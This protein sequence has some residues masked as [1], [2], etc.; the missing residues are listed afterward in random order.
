MKTIKGLLFALVVLPA[1]VLAADPAA[2][3]QEF[4]DKAAISGMFEVKASEIAVRRATGPQVKSFA[5]MMVTDHSAANAKLKALAAQKKV[6]L[7]STLDK[8]H[9]K[10]LDKLSK[11]KPGKDFDETYVDL[12]EDGH[13]K[14]VK[15]FE[16]ASKNAKDPDVSAFAAATLPTLR[17]HK[18][19][20]EALDDEDVA[21]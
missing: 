2:P 6:V 7:P 18:E 13:D 11:A 17:Q 5:E 4:Y 16:K 14:A 15:L 8:D 21:P 19:V 1:C 10:S 3:D 12:M 9:Q 20:V